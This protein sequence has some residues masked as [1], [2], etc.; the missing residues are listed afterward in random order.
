MISWKQFT[1]CFVRYMA[2][3]NNP[4][5]TSII[6]KLSESF[7]PVHIDVINESFKHNVPKGAET[8]FKVVIV[9]EN[10]S[11]KSLIDRHRQVNSVLSEELTGPVHALSIQAKTPEQWEK[12]G[13]KV[14]STPPC[15]GG[16][17]K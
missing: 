17:G 1:S 9:S 13:H 16:S 12:S 15:L 4:V 5:Q 10:F 6:K 3:V 11:G 2:H 7:K 14:A 8:H